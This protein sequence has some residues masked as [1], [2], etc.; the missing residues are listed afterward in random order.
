MYFYI[1]LLNQS[2]A[3]GF[4]PELMNTENLVQVYTL[5]NLIGIYFCGA[6]SILIFFILLLL[7]K[8]RE[9][10]YFHYSFFCFLFYFMV[11]YTYNR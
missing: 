3:I 7:V 2:P 9:K 4:A 11:L 5:S 6:I 8:N 10:I 1:S